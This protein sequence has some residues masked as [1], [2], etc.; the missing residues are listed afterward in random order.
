MSGAVSAVDKVLESVGL[1]R[2]PTSAGNTQC[3]PLG[4]SGIL[5]RLV[6]AYLHG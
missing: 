3:E 1:N 5:A 2:R 4:D 6:E